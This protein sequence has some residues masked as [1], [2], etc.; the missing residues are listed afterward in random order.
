MTIYHGLGLLGNNTDA[1]DDFIDLNPEVLDRKSF[2]SYLKIYEKAKYYYENPQVLKGI[3]TPNSNEFAEK[4]Y[5]F[6][7][8]KNLKCD[9]LFG[10]YLNDISNYINSTFYKSVI[11]LLRH[12]RDCMNSL[13]WEIL[14]K[15]NDLI[16]EYTQY[17]FCS[18]KSGEILPDV[19]NDFLKVYLPKKLPS[20]DLHIARIVI[21][22]FCDWLY[23]KQYT[24]IRINPI[25]PE[26]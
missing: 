19:C 16:H 25:A 14:E 24:H 12:Y 3:L 22:E 4:K 1:L 21:C 20:F 9:D 26:I 2:E 17:D 23:R 10:I 15:Y 11:I 6:N 5:K 8:N 7:L 13:G 18:V